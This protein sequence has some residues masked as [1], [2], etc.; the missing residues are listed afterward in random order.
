MSI[1]AISQTVLLG[2]QAVNNLGRTIATSFAAIHGWLETEVSILS[3]PGIDL[4]GQTDSAVFFNAALASLT[5]GATLTIPAG[6]VIKINSTIEIG[7]GSS[8]N[9]STINYIRIKGSG[10]AG[11]GNFIGYPNASNVRFVWGGA[12]TGPS[13]VMFQIAGPMQG[14]GLE[15]IML[16][17]QSGVLVGLQI[18]SASF[19]YCKGV[20]VENCK[21]QAI[22]SDT[23]DSFATPGFANSM[24]NRFENTNILIQSA[25]NAQGITLTGQITGTPANS[26]YNLFTN[27]TIKMP[28]AFASQTVAM[29]LQWCDSNYFTGV[30]IIGGAVAGVG[31]VFDYSVSNSSG[32][33]VISAIDNGG[34]NTKFANAGSPGQFARANYIYSLFEANGATAEQ[35]DNLVNLT[36][37]TNFPPWAVAGGISDSLVLNYP[38][39]WNVLPDDKLATCRG[40]LQNTTTTPQFAVEDHGAG[41][42]F[43][44]APIVKFG[45]LPVAPGDIQGAGHEVMLR[46]NAGNVNWQLL[47]PA[48][49][50]NAV[51]L[52]VSATGTTQ[53]GA[54][55]IQYVWN[56]VGVATATANGVIMGS[57][58]PGTE[59]VV[60]NNAAVNINVYPPSGATIDVLAPNSPFVLAPFKLQR[61]LCFAPTVYFSNA[62]SIMG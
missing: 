10:V 50:V 60:F 41:S 24:H 33:N 44:G 5:K 54:A 1:D 17:G 38:Q 58:S 43:A 25:A 8:A 12:S 22:L 30:H 3:F 42:G 52:A 4:T 39:T 28:D 62:T 19:G 27:T 7:N 23:Y 36:D 31:C 48:Q 45:N 2:A 16:D 34:C 15:N 21:S 40:L 20:S 56:L 18:L 51:N 59:Q 9:A 53:A 46:W 37:S 61:F 11:P 14:W 47:N 57:L 29:Y 6:S 49:G 26:C 13:S 32:T 55:P 35:I